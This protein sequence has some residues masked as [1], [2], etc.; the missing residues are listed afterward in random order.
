M[1]GQCY[2]Q[3]VQKTM[4]NLFIS[5]VASVYFVQATTV[6][7]LEAMCSQP[8]PRDA[9]PGDLVAILHRIRDD[10][11]N[12]KVNNTCWCRLLLSKTCRGEILGEL[13]CEG[14]SNSK[15]FLG[16]KFNVTIWTYA[17][18][19]AQSVPARRSHNP[20]FV[21]FAV[22][23]GASPVVVCASSRDSLDG[24]GCGDFDLT[25]NDRG[26]VGREVD[27]ANEQ[28]QVLGRGII[29]WN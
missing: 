25:A 12:Q 8:S 4:S 14:P 21:R 11:Q 15:K 6:K 18:E 22:I 24:L 10:N 19:H 9:P 3:D 5:V 1:P 20:V 28:G 29:G 26:I 13:R 7:Y 2:D 27:V 17:N 23:V 16:Q